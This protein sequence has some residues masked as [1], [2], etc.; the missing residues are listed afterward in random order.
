MLT[1]NALDLATCDYLLVAPSSPLVVDAALLVGI[2]KRS[3][4]HGLW[5]GVSSENNDEAQHSDKDASQ[6]VSDR[7]GTTP[8]AIRA[9]RHRVQRRT[10]RRRRRITIIIGN[11]HTHRAQ[12][13][14]RLHSKSRGQMIRKPKHKRSLR[15]C[16]N[17]NSM[18]MRSRKREK[19]PSKE[20][21]RRCTK[22]CS[23]SKPK[24]S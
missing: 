7:H 16:S 11:R 17:A 8:R 5:G 20:K 15:R 12:R 9:A 4:V 18:R 23:A 14:G 21:R 10:R 6:N 13:N 24:S 1:P 19:P 3:M 2:S 22:T